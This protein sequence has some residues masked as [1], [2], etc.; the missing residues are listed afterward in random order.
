VLRD[1]VL[2]V[3]PFSRSTA[4]EMIRSVRVYPLLVGFRGREGVDLD[5]LAE[6]LVR[7]G[8]IAA[9][10]P[11]IKELDINPLAAAKGRGFLIIDAVMRVDEAPLSGARG[12]SAGC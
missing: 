6:I 10:F 11:E 7:V 1:V 2:R 3:A 9:A 8:D 12:G 5:L 4:M